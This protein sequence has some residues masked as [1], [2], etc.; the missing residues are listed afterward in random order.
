M[1]PKNFIMT[2]SI[3]FGKL[4]DYIFP[5]KLIISNQKGMGVD[6][7]KFILDAE[8]ATTALHDLKI[9][10]FSN[11]HKYLEEKGCPTDSRNKMI[12]LE[13]QNKHYATVKFC[14]YPKTITIDIGCSNIPMTCLPAGAVRLSALLADA[15]HFLCEQSSHK[16]EIDPIEKWILTHCHKNKDGKMTYDSEKF[17]ILLEDTLGKITRAYSK[18]FPDGSIFVRLEEIRREKI[19]VLELLANMRNDTTEMR[20]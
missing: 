6:L 17:H 8:K 20:R 7:I 14:I 10:L 18:K 2:I 19:P 5:K 16:A 13:M 1:T 3:L 9:K 15:L 12:R 11:L 4:L